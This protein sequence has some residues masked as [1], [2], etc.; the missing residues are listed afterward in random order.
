VSEKQIFHLRNLIF[1]A[2]FSGMEKAANE[3]KPMF[4]AD[5]KRL[6]PDEWVLIGNPDLDDTPVLKA[7]V[8]KVRGGVVLLHSKDKREIGYKAKDAKKGYDTFVCVYTGELPH[9]RRF[10]LS[11]WQTNS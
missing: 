4:F 9:N 5:I 3:N 7:V 10:W 8:H 6:Y 11:N 2:K 1:V